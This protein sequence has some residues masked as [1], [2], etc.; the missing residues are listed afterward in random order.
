[1]VYQSSSL[2]GNHNCLDPIALFFSAKNKPLNHPE[3]IKKGAHS[4]K[5]LTSAFQR[6]WIKS[7]D[8]NKMHSFVQGS[9]L[10]IFH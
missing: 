3:G 1:M 7:C 4:V 9:D 5:G 10:L 2:T 6:S 8:R